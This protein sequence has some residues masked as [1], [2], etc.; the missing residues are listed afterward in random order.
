LAT[1]QQK[2]EGA[3]AKRASDQRGC[4]DRD[5]A[6]DLSFAG[7]GSVLMALHKHHS[8]LSI[9]HLANAAGMHPELI[10]RFVEFGLI[11]PSTSDGPHPLFSPSVVERLQC[12]LRLH[13][14]LGVNLPGIAVILEMRERVLTLRKELHHLQ[15]RLGIA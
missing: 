1:F 9:G 3:Y 6:R 15:K 8:L 11:E 13:R 7:D 12:I 4:G 10:R 2:E 5:C 14:D